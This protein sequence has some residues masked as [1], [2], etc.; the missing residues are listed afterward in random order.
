MNYTKSIE[1]WAIARGLDTAEPDK[2]LIKLMEELGELAEGINKQR[3]DQVIDSLG[4]MYVV[5]T[6][7]AMQN[8]FSIEDAIKEAYMTIKDRTGKTV[9]GVF[10]K[11]GD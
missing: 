9:D 7:F 8:G 3:R 10:I 6:I 5:M 4:D 1:A 2:Q 11:T